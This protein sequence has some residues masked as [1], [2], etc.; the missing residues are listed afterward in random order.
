[1]N[2]RTYVGIGMI[3]IIIIMSIFL[4]LNWQTAFVRT[5]KITYGDGCVETFKNENLTTPECT[6]GRMLDKLAKLA[7][8]NTNNYGGFNFTF[9]AS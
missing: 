7:H 2:K 5:V 1:M 9:N 4:A 6:N 3:I 8:N